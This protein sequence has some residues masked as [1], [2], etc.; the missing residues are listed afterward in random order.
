MLK[1]STIDF[2][3]ITRKIG[4]ILVLVGLLGTLLSLKEPLSFMFVWRFMYWG[5]RKAENLACFIAILFMHLF[6]NTFTFQIFLFSFKAKTKLKNVK[7]NTHV[8][9]QNTLHLIYQLVFS[10]LISLYFS[11]HLFLLHTH[12]HFNFYWKKT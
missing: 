7:V 1:T 5:E 10:T 6:T 4:Q 9:Y 12:T 8:E 2:I 11:L 3:F